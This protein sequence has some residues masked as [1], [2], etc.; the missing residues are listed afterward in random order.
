MKKGL[1]GTFTMACLAGVLAFTGCQ[2]TPTGR[3]AVAEL[4]PTAG[5]TARGTIH[6]YEVRDGVRV[7]ARVS[8]LTPG[9]H[10]FHLHEKGDCSAADATSAGGHFNPTGAPHGGPRDAQRHA[11]DFGNLVADSNGNAKLD[12]VAKGISFDGPTSIIGRSA[13]VHADPDDL[14]TQNPPGNAGKRVACGVVQLR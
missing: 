5:N 13:I 2:S 3:H 11:G 12:F 14:K 6:F 9:E 7:V 8:R 1:K 10:G 4:N